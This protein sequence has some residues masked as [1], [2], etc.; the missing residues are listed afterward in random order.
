MTTSTTTS[1]TIYFRFHHRA[2]EALPESSGLDISS[3]VV[4]C[5]EESLPLRL[6]YDEAPMSISAEANCDD[7]NGFRQLEPGLRRSP[8]FGSQY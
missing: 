7:S 5:E 8:L 2:L 6:E 4:L 3:S 1:T